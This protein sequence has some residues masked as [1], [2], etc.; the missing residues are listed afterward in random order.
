MS[1][2]AVSIVTQQESPSPPTL[3]R[4]TLE[5]GRPALPGEALTRRA[6]TAITAAIVAMT[7]AFSL[8][9]VTHSLNFRLVRL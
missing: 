3:A 4:V 5:Q 7:F 1:A 8:G 6:I 9:N 2:P